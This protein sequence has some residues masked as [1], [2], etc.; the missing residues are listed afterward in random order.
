MS[1]FR[2]L[3]I[4]TIVILIIGTLVV[5][6]IIWWQ[7]QNLPGSTNVPNRETGVESDDINTIKDDLGFDPSDLEAA[8]L[9]SSEINLSADQNNMINY[10]NESLGISFSYPA[11]WGSVIENKL[12]NGKLLFANFTQTLGANEVYG[13]GLNA[14][15]STNQDSQLRCSQ[16]ESEGVS[17][18]E[19]VTT[20]EEDRID[21]ET[22]VIYEY[23]QNNPEEPQALL[24]EAR[25]N[26]Q[27]GVYIFTVADPELHNEFN[28]MIQTLR[29]E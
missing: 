5:L 25:F 29:F 26:T 13:I 23:M 17:P 20:C 9:E 4:A 19:P 14:D 16:L 1:T 15:Q 6:G 2:K 11:T 10:Q 8:N 27:Q 12:A 28:T 22:V 3:L 18:E 24:R 7:R 21:G